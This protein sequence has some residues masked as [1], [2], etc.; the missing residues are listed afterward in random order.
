M[1]TLELGVAQ[2]QA[3]DG[4]PKQRWFWTSGERG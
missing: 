2:A 1:A 4:D 3:G